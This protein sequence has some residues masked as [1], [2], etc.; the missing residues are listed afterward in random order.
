MKRVRLIVTLVVLMLC[1][2]V[3]PESLSAQSRKE[4]E[5]RER[6]VERADSLRRAFL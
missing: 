3:V 5:A 6:A 1:G 2:A 4:R